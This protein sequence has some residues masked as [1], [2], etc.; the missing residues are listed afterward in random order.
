MTTLR[1]ALPAGLL[2]L[3]LPVA[4]SAFELTSEPKVAFI[5]A[6]VAQDGGWNEAIDKGRAA[7][8]EDLDLDIAVAENI[9]EEATR[10]RAAID[11]YVQRGYNIIVGTTYGY[12]EAMFEA[13]QAYPHVAFFN[14]SG[15]HNGANMES[16]YAR[17]YE[18]WYLAGMTA[19][20]TSEA[21]KIGM[22]AGFPVGVVNWDVNGFAR[23]AQAVKPGI[24]TTVVYTN[25]WWDPVKE[26][27][28]SEAILDQGADV[29]ATDL[30]AASALSA[31]EERGAGAIGYQIDMSA[32]APEG[33]LTSVVFNW[34][35]YLTPRI[36]EVIDGTWQPE[37]WGWFA[38]LASGVV[39]LAP[40]GPSVSEETRAKVA[41]A[42][43]QIIAGELQPFAGPL[44]ARD[45]T[46]VVAEGDVL[47]DDALWTMDFF[48]DGITGT[49]PSGE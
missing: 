19:A 48:V 37:E 44:M 11:L 46:E 40:F 24:D 39:D 38:G 23:G 34:E 12:S 21:D 2:A 18:A 33:I 13:A 15:V 28:V 9:P 42:K 20:D 1:A 35:A 7:L 8:A 41:E 45:G 6:S 49:M 10:L 31:A 25:S 3:S 43:A 22:L 5:Y 32:A 16:F 47:P 29:I 27:Q 26:G 4:A 17:T 14:A 30:S 36:Q